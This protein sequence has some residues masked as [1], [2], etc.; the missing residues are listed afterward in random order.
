MLKLIVT[1]KFKECSV[2]KIT[3]EATE[4]NFYK[5]K[6]KN[7]EYGEHYK[8]TGECKKCRK[9]KTT[10]Y[11]KEHGEMHRASQRK[12]SM[13]EAGR[14]T[15]K[16][17]LGNWRSKGLQRIYYLNN[18]DRFKKYKDKHGHKKHNISKEEWNSC[19]AYFSFKCAYCGI[20]EQLAKELYGHNLHKEHVI[21]DGENDLRNCVPS[22]KKCNTEKNELEFEFWYIERCE[23]YSIERLEKVREWINYDYKA[24]IRGDIVNTK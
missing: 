4:E 18:K 3:F 14:K 6:S 12:Y 23:G 19:K 20:S 16:R 5:Q 2:C 1:D 15:R 9:E 7:K 22:C 10:K 13:T 11:Q 24:F 17:S 21:N 8:L